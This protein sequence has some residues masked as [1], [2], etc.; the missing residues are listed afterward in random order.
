[1]FVSLQ[2]GARGLE[3][4][5]WLKY[6]NVQKQQITFKCRTLRKIPGMDPGEGKWEKFPLL[7][8]KFFRKKTFK[9]SEKN[10][11]HEATILLSF[12]KIQYFDIHN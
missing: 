2:S 7:N 9:F 3:R 1:M 11:R 10:V 5:I 6:Y 4:L 8:P 12:K